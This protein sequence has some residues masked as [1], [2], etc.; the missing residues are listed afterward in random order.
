SDTDAL[1][2]GFDPAYVI[3]AYSNMQRGSDKFFSRFFD[4]LAGNASIRR[5]IMLGTPA[6]K[7]KNSWA[8]EVNR[9]KQLRNKYLLYPEK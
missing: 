5:L 1:N 7:I 9:F 4:K 6:D 8:D 2:T 3:D